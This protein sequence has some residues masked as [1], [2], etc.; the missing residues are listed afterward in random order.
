MGEDLN[1]MNEADLTRHRA[2]H[3]G[4]VFQQFHL[5]THLTALENVALPMQLLKRDHANSW[6]RRL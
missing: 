4:I 6:L 1:A 5:M 2:K 3:L